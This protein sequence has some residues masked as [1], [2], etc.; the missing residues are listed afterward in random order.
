M[1]QELLGVKA[2]HR[3]GFLAEINQNP[4]QVV[5]NNLKIYY[6]TLL[7]LRRSAAQW[8]HQGPRFLPSLW[9][10]S[11]AFILRLLVRRHIQNIQAHWKMIMYRRKH[12]I[13]YLFLWVKKLFSWKSASQLVSSCCLDI[14][15]HPVQTAA[16]KNEIALRIW[17]RDDISLSQ[18][19]WMYGEGWRLESNEGYVRSEDRM[20]VWQEPAMF[21]VGTQMCM[22][23]SRKTYIW[24]SAL[25]WDMTDVHFDR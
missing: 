9:F 22:R 24:V 14:C 17:S 20:T 5:L 13:I 10:N 15:A 7:V 21:T 3:W 4:I 12:F 8:W 2:G 16:K 6:C 1:I 11:V 18:S 25:N 19:S 23:E